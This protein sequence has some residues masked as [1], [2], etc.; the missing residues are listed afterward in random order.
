[1]KIYSQRQKFTS[2]TYVVFYG[3][4]GYLGPSLRFFL[5]IDSKVTF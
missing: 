1:M 5:R 3:L 4:K 2:E